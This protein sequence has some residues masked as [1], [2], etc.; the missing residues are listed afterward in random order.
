MTGDT[1]I[2]RRADL[3]DANAAWYEYA[4]SKHC[5]WFAN[6]AL[7]RLLNATGRLIDNAE[8]T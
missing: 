4:E 5:Y 8:D 3:N 7:V 1:V 6:P 2:V